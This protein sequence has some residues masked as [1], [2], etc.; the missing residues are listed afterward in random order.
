MYEIA[1]L[2]T[3]DSQSTYSANSTPE[4]EGGTKQECKKTKQ[5]NR[6]EIRRTCFSNIWGGTC[7]NKL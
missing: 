1:Q 4:L 3:K 5:N 7:E 2:L 6:Q